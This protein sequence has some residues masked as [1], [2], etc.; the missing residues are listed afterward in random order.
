MGKLMIHHLLPQLKLQKNN[1]HFM[2]S[3]H[4]VTSAFPRFCMMNSHRSKQGDGMKRPK[5]E[6]ELSYLIKRE[7]PSYLL[8]SVEWQMK[9]EQ[10]E[11]RFLHRSCSQ[12]LMKCAKRDKRRNILFRD[13]HQMRFPFY[14]A[15]QSWASLQYAV[16]YYSMPWSITNWDAQFCQDSPISC[17]PI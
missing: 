14:N 4:S 10:H 6:G 1:K 11:E 2:P 13:N 17:K 8:Q 5:R 9:A 15:D 7:I 3:W 12:V 16:H